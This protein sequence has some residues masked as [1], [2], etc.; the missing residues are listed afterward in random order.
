MENLPRRVKLPDHNMVIDTNVILRFLR[1]DIPSQ[2]IL[3]KTFFHNV[4][5]GK[6]SGEISILVID[7]TIWGLGQ[8]YKIK[9]HIFL[10]QL[11]KILSYKGISVIEMKKEI[12]SEI[13]ETMVEKNIDFTDLYLKAVAKENKIF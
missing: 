1:N 9:R 8:A 7:E 3:A 4:E 5:L 2:T 11:I 6:E 12:V 13:L 10:P